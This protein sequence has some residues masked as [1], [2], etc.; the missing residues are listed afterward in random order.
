MLNWTD[1]VGFV[2]GA[3]TPIR[4]AWE[5][6]GIRTIGDLLETPPKRYDDYSQTITV[7]DAIHG[8]VAT[9][10]V[11]VVSF[12]KQPTFRKRIQLFKLVA[13]DDTGTITATFFQ[14]PWLV[15]EMTEGREIFLSGK[16]GVHATFGKQLNHPLWEP[17]DKQIASGRIA[18]VYGLAGTLAQKTYR[19]LVQTCFELLDESTVPK[20][21]EELGAQTGYLDL[22]KKLHMPEARTDLE[23]AR[24]GL[25][26]IEL[27]I[28]QIAMRTAVAK[29]AKAGA[30]MI[31]VHE[32]AAKRFAASLPFPLTGDQKKA[33][34]LLLQEMEKPEPVRALLQGDVG[35]G[36]TAVAAFLAA[37]VHRKEQ[38]VAILAP[39]ELLAQQHSV[40]FQRFYAGT[41]IPV[42]LFTRT[43]KKRF[44][45]GKEEL[46]T[47]DEAL[48]EIEGGNI[49]IIGTH[50]I[51]VDGRLP[52]DLALA[53][54]DEQ[55]RFGVGQRETLVQNARVD[56]LVP[57]LVSM[58]ATPI[59]RTLA[60][61]LYSDLH[62]VLLR[63]KP[64][65]RLPIETH[66]CIGNGRERAYRAI[67][68]AVSKKE[69]AYIVFP[70]IEASDTTGAQALL[71][72]YKELSKGPLEGLG[73]GIVHGKQKVKEQEEAFA[74]FKDGRTPVL[75]STTV[76]EVGVDVPEATIIMIENAERFGLAQLH[77]LR[78]RVGRAL[79]PSQCFLATDVEGDKLLRLQLMERIQDGFALAEED[80]KLRGSGRILG[81][82]QS[83][84]DLGFRYIQLTDI[85]LMKKANDDVKSFLQKEGG[86]EA[87]PTIA[88]AVHQL[89]ESTHFE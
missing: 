61:T 4:R 15:N 13:K 73:I 2:K 76:I 63:E 82:V 31:P 5:A 21:A 20:L 87:Y 25:A 84:R 26:Y 19:R 38:S 3:T 18:P 69:R 79:L 37:M 43:V 1:P 75:L 40:S 10:K 24:E 45:Q 22:L 30:P 29:A 89:Q 51:L 32:D 58:T 54:I 57:H 68:D 67:R 9:F 86:L 39:T 77:Q 17:S 28:Y 49:V 41:T 72:A 6:L 56:G 52:K 48:A 66:V 74:K 36:K 35:S 78:G 47:K 55:H 71:D 50:A 7:A 33:V 60:L 44:F 81:T 14:Q 8:D 80:L 59:P 23:Q 16:V 34:W 27:M 64:A 70:L 85:P 53:V 11:T 62:H 88:K 46:L 65:G 83:G 42:I 12:K